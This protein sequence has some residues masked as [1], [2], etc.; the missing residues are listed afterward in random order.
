MICAPERVVVVP[1]WPA[2][3]GTLRL[4]LLLTADTMTGKWTSKLYE[5]VLLSADLR[6]RRQ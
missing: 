6:G 1:Y 5:P 3:K 2:F 4:W